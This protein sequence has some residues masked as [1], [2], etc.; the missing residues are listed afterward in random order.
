[1]AL[2]NVG[3]YKMTVGVGGIEQFK[4]DFDVLLTVHLSII[5]V[6]NQINAQILVL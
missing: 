6:I 1:V 2:W 5:L 4:T 3:D